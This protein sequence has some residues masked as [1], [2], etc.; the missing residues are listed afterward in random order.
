MKLMIALEIQVIC[1][2]YLKLWKW[3]QRRWML[4][5]WAYICSLFTRLILSF[6]QKRDRSFNLD[7]QCFWF[8]CHLSCLSCFLVGFMRKLRN[9]VCL[10]SILNVLEY[11]DKDGD[12]KIYLTLVLLLTINVII[13]LWW[14]LFPIAG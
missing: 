13:K 8:M 7:L 5:V 4:S 11:I 3:L 10:L 2:V 6:M 14:D 9:G 1:Q 12:K